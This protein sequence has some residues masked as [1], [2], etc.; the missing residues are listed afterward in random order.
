MRAGDALAIERQSLPL[1]EVKPYTFETA[2]GTV[3]LKDLFEGRKQ[4][5]IYH[6]MFGPE[7]FEGCTGCSFFADH[8]PAHLEHLHSRD[9]SF[10][11]VSRTSIAKIE[12][13]KKRMGWTFPWYSS[14]GSDFNYDF[15]ATQDESVAPVLGNY[16]TKEELAKKNR[17]FEARGEQSGMSVFIMEDGEVLHSYS[18]YSRAGD[19]F[20]LTYQLLDFTPLG[21]QD[22]DSKVAF[23][24][25][26]KYDEE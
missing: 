17:N 14:L 6:F 9:T 3:T 16:M 13:F 19:Q 2:T 25:H 15:H 1:V 10:A 4:L 11:C 24:L 20:L 7:D 8:V 5:I 23:P 18:Q 21:R 26:D 12:D 22:G